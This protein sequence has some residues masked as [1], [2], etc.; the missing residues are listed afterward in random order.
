MYNNLLNDELRVYSRY[1]LKRE[2]FK[3]LAFSFCLGNVTF[4]NIVVNAIISTMK[5]EFIPT[6]HSILGENCSRIL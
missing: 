6:I 1:L 5:T 4:K 2:S 3:V